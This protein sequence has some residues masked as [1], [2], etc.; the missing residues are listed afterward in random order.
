MRKTQTRLNQRNNIEWL[1]CIVLGNTWRPE[2][3]GPEESILVGVTTVI[4]LSRTAS[5]V[6]F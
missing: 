3:V 6:P 4:V 5:H 1:S 2:V